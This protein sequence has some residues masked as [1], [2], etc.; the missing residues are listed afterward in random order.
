MKSCRK[1]NAEW[2]QLIHRTTED[3]RHFDEQRL[4]PGRVLCMEERRRDAGCGKSGEMKASLIARDRL[5]AN[6]K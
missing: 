3:E 4:Q 2:R 1:H 5:A 6:D